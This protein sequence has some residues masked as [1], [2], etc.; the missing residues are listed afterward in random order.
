VAEVV[1]TQNVLDRLRAMGVDWVQG[2]LLHRPEPIEALLE[3]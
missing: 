1:E 2:F 3:V